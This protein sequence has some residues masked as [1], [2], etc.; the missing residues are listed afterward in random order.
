MDIKDFA[1][2]NKYTKWYL[3]IIDNAQSRAKTRKEAKSILGHCEG[4]HVIPLSIWR[5]PNNKNIAYLTTKEHFIVHHL[6][7]FMVKKQYKDKMIYAM[8]QFKQGRNLTAQQAAIYMLYKHH[9]CTEGRRNNIRNARL[10]TT[11]ITC[12]H[13][14]KV[15]DPGNYRQFH[16]DMC[17]KNPMIDPSILQERSNTKREA[18]LKSI[19]NGNHKTGTPISDTPIICPHCGKKGVNTVTM[20]RWHFDRCKHRVEPVPPLQTFGLTW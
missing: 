11:K 16:G 15:S 18:T 3:S 4:H 9:P 1:V 8:S 10:Q 19:K 7:V 6:L 14:N 2:N 12:P 17:K 20:R 5:S 13:C